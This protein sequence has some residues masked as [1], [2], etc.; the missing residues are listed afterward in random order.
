MS[1]PGQ[2]RIPSK[3]T[4]LRIN[5]LR[6]LLVIAIVVIHARGYNEHFGGEQ[7]G[8]AK[9]GSA[10]GFLQELFSGVI[11]RTAVPLFFLISGYL[12]ATSLHRYSYAVFLRKR[13]RTLLIPYLLWNALVFALSCAVDPSR[14]ADAN[15]LQVLGV[16]SLPASYQFWFVRD[17][18]ILV[19]LAPACILAARIAAIPTVLCAAALWFV[20]PH[21]LGANGAPID[22][23]AICFFQVGV[24]LYLLPITFSPLA[25]RLAAIVY[26]PLALMDTLVPN[27]SVGGV[28]F[29]KAVLLV[30]IVAVWEAGGWLLRAKPLPRALTASA[31]FVFAAH[32]PL[33][34]VLMK[35]SYY[36]LRP[37]SDLTVTAIYVLA[38]AI[39]I[40]SCVIANWLFSK[41]M[42]RTH[43][44]VTGGR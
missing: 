38:V 33:L 37:G 5:T 4:S 30:G 21:W 17:L 28:E 29:H 26:V 25:I 23:A 31:F 6:F 35:L 1:N 14:F 22:P 7:L 42:P 12:T 44:I 8:P 20:A 10:A 15:P 32:E 13:V 16:T 39:T 40:V 19:A 24:T 34:S 18:I 27:A 2:I 41:L 11:A 3:E 36:V 43:A 9:L